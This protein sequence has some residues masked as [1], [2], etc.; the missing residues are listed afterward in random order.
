MF[1]QTQMRVEVYILMGLWAFAKSHNEINS[2]SKPL[3]GQTRLT[4]QP[5]IQRE[6]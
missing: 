6:S 5:I 3:G 4:N 2:A 1:L